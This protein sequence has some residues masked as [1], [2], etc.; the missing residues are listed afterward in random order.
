MNVPEPCAPSLPVSAAERTSTHGFT[1][2][3]D[4]VDRWFSKEVHVHEGPLRAYLRGSF[5]SVRDVDDVVQESFLRVWRAGAAQPIASARA[6]LFKV[7][8]H[9][10]IDD[11]RRVRRRPENSLGDSAA[12][13]VCDDGPGVAEEASR[14]ERIRLI[15][16]AVAALPVRCREIII[17]HKLRGLSQR[18]VAQRLGLAEKTVENQVALGLR[19][20]ERHLRRHGMRAYND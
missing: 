7:A 8:R 9:L 4:G 18:E 14:Q 19:H 11:L 15:G 16:L 3:S 13:D 6:F 5:P 10:A 2:A 1:V 20:C 17:L 12:L